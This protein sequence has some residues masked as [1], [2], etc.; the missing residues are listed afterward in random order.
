[1]PNSRVMV[2]IRSRPTNSFASKNIKIDEEKGTILI[3]IPKDQ[4]KGIIN[5]QQENW[6]FKFD[7]I[8]LNVSQDMIYGLT[9][10]DI[11]HGALDGIS[12]TVLA[13]GQTGAGKTFTISGSSTDFKY[14]GVIP[15]TVSDLYK[16]IQNRYE[17]QIIVRV[18]YVEI[19]NEQI[20]DLLSSIT[21]DEDDFELNS[22]VAIQED[23]VYGVYVK[24]AINV[25]CD[26]EEDALGMLF[27][28]ETNKTISEHKLNKNSSRSHSIFTLHIESR[29]RVE[30]SE[31]VTISKIKLVDLA[32]SE[33]TK[34]TGSDGQVI[35]EASFINRSLTY[36][37]QVVVAL[38]GK[39]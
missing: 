38:G 8:M 20:N 7:K 27:E 18:S 28:G 36:L 19:Y 17:K 16:E 15:R 4:T 23:P 33:R 24:G 13:Y 35:M 9:T 39:E 31:K 26:T 29:S 25:Q 10:K 32:G 12:G 3:T 6:Q 22:N 34:K 30:S 1:M 5:H 14:R 11:V 2:F 37:E 21:M